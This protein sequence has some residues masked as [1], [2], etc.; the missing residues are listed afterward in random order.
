MPTEPQVVAYFVRHGSTELN[1]SNKFRG[2][3]DPPLDD[4]GLKDAQEAKEFLKDQSLGAAFSSDRKRTETTAR[5]VLQPRGQTYSADPNLRAWN[6]GYLGG[7]DK[8]EFSDD[9]GYFQR[10]PEIQVPR[11]ESLN[12]FRDRVRPS[13]QNSI[14]SGS[15]AAPSITFSH[16]S[17]LKEVSNMIHGD[18]NHENVLPGGIIS[19]SHQDGKYAV[20]AVLKPK[21]DATDKVESG[22]GG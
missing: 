10:H 16:S 20:K 14:Q 21:P 9:I 3:L 15:A 4:H 7:Q 6:V 19:I 12:Q 22:Y 5:A 2:P 18:H 11:G 1:D 8:D 13:I 17:V